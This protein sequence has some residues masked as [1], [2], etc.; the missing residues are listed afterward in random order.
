MISDED[1]VY[2]TQTKII[3]MTVYDLLSKPELVNQIV[4]SFKPKMTY[5]EYIT[6]LQT[7]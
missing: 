2:L 6:Y 3:A 5:Q 4:K 1:E 7:Q